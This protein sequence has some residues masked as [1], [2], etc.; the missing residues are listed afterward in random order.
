MNQTIGNKVPF[1]P[2]NI[3]ECLCPKCPVQ[4]KSQCVSGKIATIAGALSKNP[5]NAEEIPGLYCVTGNATCQDLDAEQPCIC[6]GCAVYR[7]YNLENGM[8]DGNYCADGYA[9]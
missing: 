9:K 1:T 4:S 6:D 7:D 2:A 5:L 8:P 3:G